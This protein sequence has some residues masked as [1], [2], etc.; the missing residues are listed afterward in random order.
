M[1]TLDTNCKLVGLP[2]HFRGQVPVPTMDDLHPLPW[3]VKKFSMRS[4]F[5][6]TCESVWL[7]VDAKDRTVTECTDSGTAHGIVDLAHAR[8]T[9]AAKCRYSQPCSPG[10]RFEGL[11]YGNSWHCTAT[12][13][14]PET[15]KCEQR[16]RCTPQCGWEPHNRSIRWHCA[17]AAAATPAPEKPEDKVQRLSNELEQARNE[18][19]LARKAEAEAR[20]LA[21]MTKCRYGGPHVWIPGPC[22]TD[23]SAREASGLRIVM[24]EYHCR[25]GVTA[26]LKE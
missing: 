18:M 8:R 11:L 2:G 16:L 24:A 1:C 20:I 25:C 15:A 26:K 10:C 17:A 7:V 23:I 13:E 9:E 3:K 14:K 12:P 21:F 19:A 22:Q 6:E 4:N 5:L